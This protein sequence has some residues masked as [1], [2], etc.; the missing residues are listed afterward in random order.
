MTN[1]Q[2]IL[3]GLDTARA[4]IRKQIV[5]AI[6][7]TAFDLEVL[8][9]YGLAWT[10]NLLDSIGCGIY[11]DGVLIDYITPVAEA[12]DPRS[13]A[14]SYPIDARKVRGSEAPIYGI[15]GI[16]KDRPYWG[17]KELFDILNDPPPQVYG[18]GWALY[19]VAAMPYSEV[20]DERGYDILQD[21]EVVPIFKTHIQKLN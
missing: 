6:K 3:K 4:I 7:Q 18:K 19:Y 2:V 13:G 20:L 11:E 14:E 17:E 9:P 5:D 12:T 16:D 15:D 1:E 8:R 10:H 21:E